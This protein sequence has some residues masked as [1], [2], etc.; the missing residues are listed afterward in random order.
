MVRTKH[1]NK[2]VVD[3]STGD[4][5]YNAED[6]EVLCIAVGEEE[7]GPMKQVSYKLY[8]SQ[9]PT[10][11][12]CTPDHH[13]TLVSSA[14]VPSISK[15]TVTWI[16]R[17]NRHA[18]KS[19]PVNLDLEVLAD[20]FYRDVLDYP[21]DA[22][23]DSAKLHTHVDTVLD[24]H[25]H[26]GH[27]EHSSVIDA[28]LTKCAER[29][30]DASPAGFRDALHSSIDAY[31]FARG[32]EVPAFNP[33]E[34][35]EVDDDLI[36]D[37]Q[38]IYDIDDGTI[39]TTDFPSSDP[40]TSGFQLPDSDNTVPDGE[41]P[42]SDARDSSSQDMLGTS[43]DRFEKVRASIENLKCKCE[44]HA[45]VR[46]VF[47]RFAT[48]AQAQLAHRIL[49]GHHHHLIDPM[50]VYVSTLPSFSCSLPTTM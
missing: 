45:G 11:F 14:C 44:N 22:P 24:E 39:L 27:E 35:N 5:L 38:I 34:L 28:Y 48:E 40:F 36:R 31:M 26:N 33:A 23:P 19:E 49:L 29:E 43:R 32:D 2:R 46:K 18:T 7:E 13:L 10:S 6:Q 20:Y 16:T 8:D 4:I 3:I 21:D 50:V 41:I 42:A 15:N 47:R 9:K 1:G 12:Q 25:F 37:T 30:L 17:C